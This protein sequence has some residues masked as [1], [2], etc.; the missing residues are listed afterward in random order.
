[1]SKVVVGM[2]V[3]NEED[4][5][6]YCLESFYNIVDKI[7]IVEGAEHSSHFAAS[8]EG[9]STDKTPEIIRSFEEQPEHKIVW[10][11][12]GFVDHQRELRQECLKHVDPDT[13]IFFCPDGDEVYDE[14]E[15]KEAFQHIMD[16]GEIHRVALDH[17]LFCEDFSHVKYDLDL[18]ITAESGMSMLR[19]YRHFP[20]AVIEN[21]LH[22][23]LKE[24][25]KDV[26]FHLTNIYHLG[27]VRSEER[28]IKKMLWTIKRHHDRNTDEYLD[29]KGFSDEQIIEWIKKENYPVN[30]QK[31]YNLYKYN[32]KYPASVLNAIKSRIPLYFPP[33]GEARPWFHI[34]AIDYL[35]NYLKPYMN[36]LE[37]GA[38]N[39]T[40]W[41]SPRV[42][43][44][45][46]LEHDQ[47]FA[48]Y[49][50]ANNLDNVEMNVLPRPY[51]GFVDNIRDQNFD[52]ILIDGRDRNE[53]AMSAFKKLKVGSL[54]AW[55]DA[56]R[57]EYK[58][59][60]NFLLSNGYELV[61][62]CFETLMFRRVK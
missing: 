28:L 62:K 9:L 13:D 40:V 54:L 42:K 51:N 24:G 34:T 8:P 48:D 6:R 41:F 56:E 36:I 43:R 37:F 58:E 29:L 5:L 25:Y 26:R 30:P 49:V 60:V 53:C 50:A 55:D 12:K 39:S 7:I 44:I 27:W 33:D 46:S 19:L 16:H 35:R 4:Y 15:L 3:L 20:D 18:C 14:K 1:M 22:I 47:K 61:E 38:G 21:G 31:R 11:R 17:I 10:I 52:F 45:V 32:G 57:A 2:I 23:A 59:G